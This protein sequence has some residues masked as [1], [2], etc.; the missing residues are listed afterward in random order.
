MI[1]AATHGESRQQLTRSRRRTD[2]G[3][4]PWRSPVLVVLLPPLASLLPR[5]WSLLRAHLQWEGGQ[6]GRQHGRKLAGR[7]G[8]P[9]ETSS[10]EHSSIASI[11]R[12]GPF[13]VVECSR[14]GAGCARNMPPARRCSASKCENRAYTHASTSWRTRPHV[15]F[16]R[17]PV[18]N[19]H[20]EDASPATLR[21]SHERR[22]EDPH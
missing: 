1:A 10:S 21:R 20:P 3:S 5:P 18:N 22:Q 15:V 8:T 6:A 4:H 11:A 17:F 9:R 2:T 12:S 14:E 16:S 13:M 7:R 19:R